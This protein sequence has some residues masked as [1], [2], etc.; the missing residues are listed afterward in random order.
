MVDLGPRC[1]FLKY[2][3]F[4]FHASLAR[5]VLLTRQE[6]MIELFYSFMI[7]QVFCKAASGFKSVPECFSRV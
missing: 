3:S 4:F 7:C 2:L 1:I 5:F 6:L